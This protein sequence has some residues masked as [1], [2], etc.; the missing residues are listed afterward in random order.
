MCSPVTQS[1]CYAHII[2]FLLEKN[3]FEKDVYNVPVE[4][5]YIRVKYVPLLIN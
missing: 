3:A 5:R 2:T 1:W 4:R